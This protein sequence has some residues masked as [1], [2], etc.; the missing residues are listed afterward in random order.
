MTARTIFFMIVALGVY[1]AVLW[2]AET[3]NPQAHLRKQYLQMYQEQEGAHLQNPGMLPTPPVVMQEYMLVPL[4]A[5]AVTFSF[6]GG[7]H[8]YLKKRHWVVGGWV[9]A[10]LVLGGAS[11]GLVVGG[12]D[13][14]T[15]VLNVLLQA[16]ACLGGLYAGVLAT[17][18]PEEGW[19]VRCFRRS[20]EM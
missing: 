12:V 2:T 17:R 18:L 11:S 16:F 20:K 8:G 3:M 7:I 1:W 19:I 10:L 6:W 9:L 13:G 5:T 15:L 4:L 14:F